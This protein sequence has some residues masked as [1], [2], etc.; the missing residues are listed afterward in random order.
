M[1]MQVS[2]HTAPY[3]LIAM[4][5]ISHCLLLPRPPSLVPPAALLC[6][7]SGPCWCLGWACCWSWRCR[8]WRWAWGQT[9]TGAPRARSVKHTRAR[10]STH[11]H[12]L[13]HM[14]HAHTFATC[15]HSCTPSRLSLRLSHA[16]CAS[17]AQNGWNSDWG[18]LRIESCSQTSGL[19]F[20]APIDRFDINRSV[21]GGEAVQGSSAH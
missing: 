19:C 7:C 1:A 21:Q 6:P 13:A 15:V 5:S 10:S 11:I 2:E 18:L 3:T 16:L 8:C 20:N 14:Q 17:L 4:A 9:S 12:T